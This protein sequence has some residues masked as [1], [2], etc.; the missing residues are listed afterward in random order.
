MS[1]RLQSLVWD[2]DEYS[3]NTLLVLVKLC[4]WANDD[5]KRVFPLIETLAKRTRQ[6]VR[7]TQMCLRHLEDDGILIPSANKMGGRSKRLEYNINVE[8]VKNLHRL[9]KGEKE[10]KKRVKST[11][12][13]GEIHDKSPTP[14]YIDIHQENHKYNHQDAR[15]R[16]DAEQKIKLR[17]AQGTSIQDMLNRICEILE[18][19]LLDDPVRL[20]WRTQLAK[21]IDDGLDFTKDI[22]PAVEIARVNGKP[23]LSYIRATAF[24]TLKKQAKGQDNDKKSPHDNFIAGADLAAKIL[25]ERGIR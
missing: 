6:S 5:G 2:A 8:R 13:K 11:T 4:D 21:M 18:I 14:P 16:E 22:I 25:A 20:T 3:G 10:R 24:N 19:D 1:N 12:I 9:E 23:I 17:V 15:T 7:S